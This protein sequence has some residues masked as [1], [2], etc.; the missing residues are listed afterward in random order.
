MNKNNQQEENLPRAGEEN[1]RPIK[2][3]MHGRS[4]GMGAYTKYRIFS[5]RQEK[6]IK[7]HRTES[8]KTGNHWT[9]IWW[10]LPGTYF[11]SWVDISNSGKHNCGYGCLFVV[12]DEYKI[13]EWKGRIPEFAKE[14]LC[15]ECFNVKAEW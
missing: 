5:L 15:D 12:R 14:F 10:L 7:P 4:T 3:V 2:V 9:D 13:V 1:S 6:E 8:S 11:V